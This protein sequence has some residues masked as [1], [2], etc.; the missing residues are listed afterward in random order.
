[1]SGLANQPHV[2][3]YQPHNDFP[4]CPFSM[5]TFHAIMFQFDFF[6]AV[7]HA[8]TVLCDQYHGGHVCV[9]ETAARVC[10]LSKGQG[11]FV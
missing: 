11:K 3:L 2:R 5:P 1:M 4:Q 7:L 6:C 10:M 9:C 8:R